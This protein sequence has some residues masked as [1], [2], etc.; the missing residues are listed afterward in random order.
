MKESDSNF[1]KIMANK[2]TSDL[3][4]IFEFDKESYVPEALEA[5]EHELSKRKISLEHIDIAKKEKEIHETSRD[6][7]S[8]ENLSWWWYIYLFFMPR[9]LKHIISDEF[10]VHG[11]ETKAKQVFTKVTIKLRLLVLM[12]FAILVF[13]SF[14]IQ[15][16]FAL[17]SGQ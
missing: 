3:I 9:Y 16:L 12:Y 14:L 1:S 6:L 8:K 11:Y 5:A 4:Y 2:S 17:L 10:A 15:I 7:K 13:A